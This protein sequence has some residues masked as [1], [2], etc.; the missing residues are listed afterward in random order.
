MKKQQR[1]VQLSLS[2]ETLSQLDPR[3]GTYVPKDP[4][5]SIFLSCRAGCSDVTLSC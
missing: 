5:E 1:S 4:R 2:R 3:G